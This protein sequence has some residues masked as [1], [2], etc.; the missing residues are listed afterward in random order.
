MV[1]E[2]C[3]L[4][5]GRGNPGEK[6]MSSDFSAT[7]ESCDAQGRG[8]RAQGTAQMQN[9]QW[10]L[11]PLPRLLKTTPKYLRHLDSSLILPLHE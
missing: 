1:L 11:P 2:R 7:N 10:L 8:Y 9:G 5:K 3:F 6:E 4:N